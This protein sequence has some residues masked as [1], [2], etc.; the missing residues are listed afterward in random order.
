MKNNSYVTALKL[1]L[2]ICVNKE[3]K[4]R[5]LNTERG[6]DNVGDISFILFLIEIS[7][8]VARGVLMLSKVVIGSVSNAP[9]LAPAER[10]QELK[11]RVPFE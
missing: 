9:K 5:T 3:G 10:E 11:V 6:L 7:Q 1:L 4:N 8:I 2:V